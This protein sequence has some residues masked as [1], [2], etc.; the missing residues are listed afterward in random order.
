MRETKQIIL[1]LTM[2]LCMMEGTASKQTYLL[3][4]KT[5]DTGVNIFLSL[6]TLIFEIFRLV[7]TTA[8]TYLM[9]KPALIRKE[10][11]SKSERPGMMWM[12]MI[13][14]V[15]AVAVASSLENNVCVGWRAAS[16]VQPQPLYRTNLVNK[17]VYSLLRTT[18]IYNVFNVAI[19]SLSTKLF[20]SCR[21]FT[22]CAF[23]GFN[24]IYKKA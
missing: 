17:R 16:G 7:Q 18:C 24:R 14:T 9:V 11:Q 21:H 10:T 22:F 12:R 20:R 23:H 6:E 19:L 5:E 1:V 8:W 13:A 3:E 2:M 15:V 4:M